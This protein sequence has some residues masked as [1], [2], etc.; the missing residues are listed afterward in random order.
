V[1]LLDVLLIS[2]CPPFP[3]YFG[4][5][6]I[7]YHLARQ[8]SARHHHIDLVAFYTKPEAAAD[9]PR[10]ERFFRHIQ[11][12]REPSRGVLRY[13]WRL[14]GEHFFPGKA[15]EAWSGEMWQT[16]Q[17]R[18]FSGRY[19]VIQ[20]FGGIQVYEYREAV[21]A[22][23]NLI[24]PY[25]SY[26]LYLEH[27]LAQPT[28]RV[29]FVRRAELSM[30][31][32]YEKR[33][34]SGFDQVVV[35]AQ[36]DADALHQINSALPISVIPNGVDTDYFTP[37]GQEPDEPALLFIGNYDYAPNV[38]AALQLAR[39]IFP[40]VK[41]RVPQARLMLVGNAPP[42]VLQALAS[43]DID[44]TGTVPD[45]RPYYEQALIFVSPLQ[46]GA[47]IKNKILEAMAMQK[48]I[49]ATP[50]SCDGIDLENEKHLLIV[51]TSEAIVKAIVRLIKD[52]A[53]RQRIALASR[54]LIESRYTW[55]RVATQYETLYRTLADRKAGRI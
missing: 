13:L 55:Q 21:K 47:G 7:P 6:L 18:I 34:F 27:E 29:P 31:R 11:L 24:V 51:D 14:Y 54:Q 26:S 2:R 32:R 17:E 3:L 52:G 22:Y 40:A 28:R 33:M 8:L 12:I 9:I 16:V 50:L 35:V 4:D 19:D 5:R 49:V 44:V 20:L 30:T 23:A 53:L 45:V 43:A 1:S 15:R 37:N 41:L 36:A 38:E 48:A 25:E 39:H 46:S 42:P 10:Y